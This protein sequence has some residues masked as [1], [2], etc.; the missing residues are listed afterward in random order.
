VAE[1]IV[2]DAA[3]AGALPRPTAGPARRWRPSWP[4]VLLALLLLAAAIAAGVL[5]GL[6]R[7][8]HATPRAR[9]FERAGVSVTAPPGWRPV[10]AA[11]VPG[12]VLDRP[13]TLGRGTQRLLAG[14]VA[15]SGD[16]VLPPAFA[17]Q[18]VRRPQRAPARI[19]GVSGYRYV[20]L[21]PRGL[22]GTLDLLLVPA[23]GGTV[24]FACTV[25]PLAEARLASCD[26]LASTLRLRGATPYELQ[27]DSG[28]GQAL[29]TTLRVLDRARN[30]GLQQ[31]R[32]SDRPRAQGDGAAAVARAYQAAGLSLADATPPPLVADR[33]GAVVAALRGAG[34]A[35]ANLARAAHLADRS[36][37]VAARRAARSAEAEVGR[38]LAA[39]QPYG[40]GG[41]TG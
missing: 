33:A 10:A 11:S 19:G 7:P 37:Y 41:G 15:A 26:G 16:T 18:L 6:A 25:P 21:E 35:Y 32:A 2:D 12:L 36:G 23:A 14:R 8:H 38:A 29:A 28:F 22:R 13:V 3:L 24:A 9:T 34:G 1:T 5:F 4:L 40:Y 27:P 30:A 20:G 39:L 17:A 31:L